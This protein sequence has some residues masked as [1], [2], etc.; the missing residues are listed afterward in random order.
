MTSTPCGGGPSVIATGRFDAVQFGHGEVHEHDDVRVAG[1]RRAPRR[2][3]CPFSAS[4]SEASTPSSWASMKRRPLR[5]AGWSST[6][7]MRI[8]SSVSSHRPGGP[9]RGG[10]CSGSITRQTVP[11]GRAPC[12]GWGRGQRSTLPHG[13]TGAATPVG[14]PGSMPPPSSTTSIVSAPPSSRSRGRR[15]GDSGGVPRHVGER[16]AHDPVTGRLDGRR[17]NRTEPGRP[18]DDGG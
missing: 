15:R 2:P 6:M 3:R 13:G 9:G 11:P 18:L 5:N 14:A 16:L 12:P 4:P 17:G 10:W 7:T 1:P 8:G